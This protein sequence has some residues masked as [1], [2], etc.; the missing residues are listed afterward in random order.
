MAVDSGS[1]ELK[2]SD[3]AHM[4]D[5]KYT[6]VIE[7]KLPDCQTLTEVFTLE[8]EY[9]DLFVAPQS[10]ITYYKLSDFI[11]LIKGQAFTVTLAPGFPNFID[12]SDPT[13][14]KASPTASASP[15]TYT[16]R[17]FINDGMISKTLQ[18]TLVVSPSIYT[19]TPP[20]PT[21]ATPLTPQTLQIGVTSTYALPES[22]A[23][24]TVELGNAMPFTKYRDGVFAFAPEKEGEYV[25]KIVL[26]DGNGQSVYR[27]RVS[28]KDD[29]V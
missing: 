19:V 7:G 8:G 12:F 28:V 26:K 3:V 24:I 1:G 5:G 6:I 29:R 25:V 16:V 14:L 27:L 4:G 15:G 22:N 17:L 11:D 13:T 10:E 23:Q 18:L 2:L 21:F 9:N 20:P